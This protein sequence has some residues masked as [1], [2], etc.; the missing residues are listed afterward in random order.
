L[1]TDSGLV[2]TAGHRL[3]DEIQKIFCRLRLL[4]DCPVCCVVQATAINFHPKSFKSYIA[5]KNFIA[6]RYAPSFYLHQRAIEWAKVETMKLDGRLSGTGNASDPI[7]HRE[8][9]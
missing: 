3:A 4:N 2:V 5:I 1:L 8:R 6:S 9:F 7:G